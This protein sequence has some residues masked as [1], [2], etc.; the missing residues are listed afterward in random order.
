MKVPPCERSIFSR[1]NRAIEQSVTLV[2]MQAFV[3][4]KSTALEK[5]FLLANILQR[6]YYNKNWYSGTKDIAEEN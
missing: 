5:I 1:I 4:A 3:F 2:D 6:Y